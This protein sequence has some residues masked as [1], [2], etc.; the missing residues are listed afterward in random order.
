MGQFT[1]ELV[2]TYSEK[3][4]KQKHINQVPVERKSREESID[5]AGA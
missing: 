4:K 5:F 3:K 2:V 1:D